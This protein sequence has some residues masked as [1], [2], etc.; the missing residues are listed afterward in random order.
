[1]IVC[2]RVHRLAAVILCALV[3]AAGSVAC[4]SSDSDGAETEAVHDVI[5]A[6]NAALVGAFQTFDM[7]DLSTVATEE[8]ATREFY[9]MAALGEGGVRMHAT[10]QSIEFGDVT[11]PADGEASVTTTEVWDYDHVSLDTSETVRTERGVV[12]HLR[13]DLVR[14]ED[15]WLVDAV[16]SLDEEPASEDATTGEVTTP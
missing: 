3:L 13:Y 11:F 2:P 1:M 16:T 12:Y 6:Y 10:L 9:L 8:Q 15:R 5:R 4:F 14:F 7:N